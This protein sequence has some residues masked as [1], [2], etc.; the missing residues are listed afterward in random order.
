MK[1]VDSRPYR[2]C[3]GIMLVN[4]QNEVF[5]ARRIGA[6]GYH[7][8]MPQGGIDNNES[9]RE[10]AFREMKEEIGTN[11]A[12]IIGEC[13]EWY[14]Y[15]LPGKLSRQIWKGQY[16]GQTQKWVALRFTGSDSDINI[17]TE[18]PEFIS[19]QW[20]SPEQLVQRAVPFKQDV[21]E[22]LM[23]TFKDEIGVF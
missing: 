22:N 18:E 1:Q 3:V 9:P 4:R 13:P 19:W 12:E 20:L 23:D 6:P 16:R 8:Q 17:E 10:A 7:W 15:D 14:S 5:I 21:Y 11:N 2:P